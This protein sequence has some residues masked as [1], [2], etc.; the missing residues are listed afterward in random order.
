MKAWKTA[1]LALAVCACA[2]ISYWATRS[3]SDSTLPAAVAVLQERL[4]IPAP[5]ELRVPEGASIDAPQPFAFDAAAARRAVRDGELRVSLPDGTD[6][7]VRIERNYT[8]ES[9]HWN[10]VGRVDTPT[11][12]HPMVMTFGATS[13]FGVLPTPDGESLRVTTRA[14]RKVV[15]APSGSLVPADLRDPALL[16]DAIVLP[17]P[18]AVASTGAAG[19]P[20]RTASASQK[21]RV[22]VAAA[23]P[24]AIAAA[25]NLRT[26]AAPIDTTPVDITVLPLYSEGMEIMWGSAEELGTAIANLFAIANQAHADSG[27][28]VHLVQS[29]APLAYSK[30]TP[31]PSNRNLLLE[32]S[33]APQAQYVRDQ[34]GDLV[35]LFKAMSG[36]EACGMALQTSPAHGRTQTFNAT[37]YS[38]V[39]LDDTCSPLALAHEIGHNLGAIHEREV[40]TDT[41]GEIRKGAYMFSHGLRTEAFA[42]IMAMPRSGQSPVPY[43][44]NPDSS[45]CGAPCGIVDY[46]DEVR[47]F[48][49]MAPA[50]AAFW[51]DAGTI[52]I[53]DVEVSEPYQVD[54]VGVVEVRMSG[55]APVGGVTLDVT[56]EPGGTASEADFY[57]QDPTIT[58]PEGESIAYLRVYV[59]AD[60]VVE[61]DEYATL[62][63]SSVNHAGLIVDDTA[64]F[65]IF[66]PQRH[67]LTG[68]IKFDGEVPDRGVYLFLSGIEDGDTNYF[69]LNLQPPNY[70][71]SVVVPFGTQVKL[72]RDMT[73]VEPYVFHPE[74]QITPEVRSDSDWSIVAKKGVQVTLTVSAAAGK[75]LP[76]KDFELSAIESDGDAT[77]HWTVIP[78]SPPM[79]TTFSILV[80]PGHDLD[81]SGAVDGFS[82]Y[83]LKDYNLT[84]DRHYNVVLDS[85]PTLRAIPEV[86]LQGNT[87]PLRVFLEEPAPAGG[88]SFRCRTVDR[89][90]KANVHYVPVTA[91]VNIPANASGYFDCGT[92]FSLLKPVPKLS[93]A[94]DVVIDQVVGANVPISTVSIAIPGTTMRTGGPSQPS[95]AAAP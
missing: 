17:T 95:P 4:G 83:R 21:Q 51:G 8:D 52:A 10:L 11:G 60:Q 54:R 89:T 66:E 9:G 65:T 19:T 5:V 20:H 45:A 29:Q 41:T 1:S 57:V 84:T 40:E 93:V 85:R 92:A 14:G 44:S 59:A 88:V 24:S 94:L 35:V 63:I 62:R 6:Y 22:A 28:R 78:V 30:T 86:R 16:N 61:G 55:P 76:A 74:W 23:A 72:L 73:L 34:R 36:L 27:S 18:D 48:N 79:F 13:V 70:A 90:A 38:V 75:S 77:V 32:I 47:T 15:I 67:V 81:L 3:S 31:Y 50:V 64:T 39:N 82:F 68:G 37:A 33:S 7:P 25:T 80:Y 26:A 43:F 58:I 12:A 2:G 46:S 56:V 53:P 49:L 42:T 87:S 71:W 69:E 91:T